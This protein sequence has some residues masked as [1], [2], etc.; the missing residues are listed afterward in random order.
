MEQVI[1][2][3]DSY[4]PGQITKTFGM[5]VPLSYTDRVEMYIREN[6]Y[7]YAS[8][9]TRPAL[10][11]I[12]LDALATLNK[13]DLRQLLYSMSDNEI[14][15]YTGIY[16]PYNGRESLIR[17]TVK[18]ILSSKSRFMYPCMRSAARSINATTILFTDIT[19]T[20]TFMVC[21][22]TAQ[23]YYSYELQELI[24]AFHLDERTGLMDFRHPED[25]ARHFTTLEVEGLKILLRCFNPTPEIETLIG[26]IDQGLIFARE[27]IEY[28]T[29]ARN[30]L[31]RLNADGK[32]HVRA[33]LY[34][35]FYIGMY[36]RRWRGPGYPYPLREADT[37]REWDP[38]VKVQD[39]L[40]RARDALDQMSAATI[41]YCMG[42]RVCE[43]KV[44]GSIEQ[45]NNSLGTDWTQVVRGQFC[46]RMASSKFVGTGLHFL[47]VLFH[48]NIEGVD[49]T[50]VARIV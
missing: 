8:L 14:H 13:R 42:L 32:M 46:I 30:G 2:Y 36:M 37:R 9:L 11:P 3:L 7:L 20:Q 49:T 39:E 15:T 17:N 43:Y 22:G 6:I 33:F 26:R 1:I 40:I 28:D 27:K 31:A 24:G 34:Q 29:T 45:H 44:G 38:M 5:V 23:R 47:R 12:P 16:V 4:T 21:Y 50:S 25:P 35:L 10:L 48:E 41:R 18:A 19:D